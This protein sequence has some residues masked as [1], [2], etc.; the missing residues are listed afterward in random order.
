VICR[1]G[2]PSQNDVGTAR[3][4]W[5]SV[6]HT[7]TSGM[8]SDGYISQPAHAI[9]AGQ[10][11]SILDENL[12]GSIPASVIDAIAHHDTGWAESDLAALEGKEKEAPI[13][14]LSVAPEIGVSAWRRSISMA[15]ALSPLAELLTTKHFW[16]L[17]P[18][19]GDPVHQEFIKDQELRIQRMDSAGYP[20]SD[21]DRFTSAL[22]F[23]DLLSLHLC[24][25]S[26][27]SVRI[28]LAHPADPGARSAEHVTISV[29]DGEVRMDRRRCWL[30][31]I[32]EV[33]GWSRSDP[34]G[35]T[36]ARFRWSF[37]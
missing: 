8:L 22:G 17:A 31:G 11:A 20:A 6:V 5:E 2:S 28:P 27:S 3:G 29:T 19:D 16:L 7:Q 32:A 30:T 24:S 33:P 10:I 37:V 25:G 12:F 13:S 15:A 9:L 36:R 14:F 35:L 4:A 23:C 1:A 34:D 26:A 18:R 21:V